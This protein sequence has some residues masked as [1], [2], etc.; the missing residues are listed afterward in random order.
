MAK[1]PIRNKSNDNPYKLGFDEDKNTY[2]VEF[3]DN[4][5]V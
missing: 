5:K 1:M 2:T 4:Q 3:I